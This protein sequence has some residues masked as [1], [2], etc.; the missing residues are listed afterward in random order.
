MPAGGEVFHQGDAGDSL[1][2]VAGGA[3]AAWVASEDDHG[4]VRVGRFAPGD[5]FGEMA[6]FTG[7]PRSATIRAEVASTILQLPRERFLVLVRREPT[8]SLT[9]AATLSERLRAANAARAEHAAFVTATVGEALGRL[10]AGRRQA[11]LEASLLETPG[12][13]P[14]RALFGDAAQ[15]VAAD[16]SALGAGAPVRRALRE[17][18]ERELGREPLAA[19]AESLAARLIADGLWPDALGVLARA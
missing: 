12:P 10:P 9:I 14:L 3:L 4:A 8:I 11:V 19:C 6:L 5:L 18:L 17:H 13:A 7:E 2:I 16:C 15:T 1:Y